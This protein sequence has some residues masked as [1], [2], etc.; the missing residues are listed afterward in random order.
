MLKKQDMISK[1]IFYVKSFK[2][3]VKDWS[4][5]VRDNELFSHLFVRNVGVKSGV[6]VIVVLVIKIVVGEVLKKG[7]V[8]TVLQVLSDSTLMRI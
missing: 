5:Y 7:N 2:G 6:R 3:K 1:V 4:C 8:F